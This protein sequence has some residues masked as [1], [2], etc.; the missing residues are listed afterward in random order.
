MVFGRTSG[1]LLVRRQSHLRLV[2]QSA[3]GLCCSQ[4]FPQSDECHPAER[5]HVHLED[6]VPA[7]RRHRLDLHGVVA[8]SVVLE[9]VGRRQ[10]MGQA[11]KHQNLRQNV[12]YTGQL[13]PKKLFNGVVIKLYFNVQ[14]L[15]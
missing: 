8:D 12:F 6:H 10:R 3:A 9:L 7:L 15:S 11:L 14:M 1:H 4:T 13:K 5:V 2:G